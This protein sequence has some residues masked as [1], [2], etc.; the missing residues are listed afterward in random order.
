MIRIGIICPSEIAFRRFLPAL[1][2]SDNYEYKGVAVA[3]KEEWFG[4]HAVNVPDE[5]F[6]KI[7]MSEMDKA[8]QFQSQFGGE[9][10]PSYSALVCSKDVDAVYIPLPPALHFSWAKYALENN[11]HVFVEKPS[12][13]SAAKTEEIAKIARQ[14]NLAVHEN[15]MFVFHEQIRVLKEIVQ[16]GEIGDVR[17]YRIDFGFPRR[18]RSDFRYSKALGGGALLDCGGYTLKYANILLGDT[19]RIEQASLNYLED[20]SVDMYGSGVMKNESGQIVQLS[21][22]MDNAYKCSVEIWGSRARIVS[23]RILT[24]PEGFVP[25]F[26]RIDNDGETTVDL[27]ADDTFLKSLEHFI[28]CIED[29]ETRAKQYRD[30]QRQADLVEGFIKRASESCGKAERKL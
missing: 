10:Y 14:N 12:T 21:F 15:Y 18:D 2:K 20:F 17:L 26:R 9:I 3:S 11:K 13:D 8:G 4:E 27:P 1:Q 28:R 24:A 5:E 19:A 16:S 30:I 25:R 29:N 22:G 7:R 6:L 23:D